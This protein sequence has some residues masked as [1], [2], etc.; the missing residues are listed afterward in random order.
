MT[1]D[2][3][4]RQY[5]DFRRL[6][7]YLHFC[8]TRALASTSIPSSVAPDTA[9]LI[10]YLEGLRDEGHLKLSPLRLRGGETGYRI[11]VNSSLAILARTV[12]EITDVIRQH[13]ETPNRERIGF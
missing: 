3:L 13:S 1:C 7:T 10:G 2:D 4:L 5:E 11:H 9:V 8:R 12:D 6:V